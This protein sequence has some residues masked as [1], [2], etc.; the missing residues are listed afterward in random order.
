MPVLLPLS[1]CFLVRVNTSAGIFSISCFIYKPAV[2]PPADF[3]K[4]NCSTKLFANQSINDAKYSVNNNF[5]EKL[6][7]Y[8]GQYFMEFL[9]ARTGK[10]NGGKFFTGC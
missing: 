6:K 3:I 1:I 2:H 10:Q 8:S 5:L 7:Q 4:Q 9:P